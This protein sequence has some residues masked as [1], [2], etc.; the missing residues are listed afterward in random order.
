MDAARRAYRSAWAAAGADARGARAFLEQL[1]GDRPHDAAALRTFEAAAARLRVQARAKSLVQALYA[2]ERKRRVVED[3]LR[4]PAALGRPPYLAPLADAGVA[5][6]GDVAATF[7]AALASR[8]GDRMA[9]AARAVLD[10]LGDLARDFGDHEA[11]TVRAITAAA[12]AYERNYREPL[13]VDA[14]N[15]ATLRAPQSQ[16]IHAPRGARRV[17][18]AE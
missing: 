7:A 9:G 18:I 5:L 13:V 8:D 10:R 17:T 2:L 12:D 15:L 16:P 4:A 3:A 11:L 14:V 1:R 6:D